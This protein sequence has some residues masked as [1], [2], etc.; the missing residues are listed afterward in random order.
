MRKT[1]YLRALDLKRPPTR[2][3]R[4]IA[5]DET[6]GL[7]IKRAVTLRLQT[8][9]YRERASFMGVAGYFFLDVGAESKQAKIVTN[10]FLKLF[11]RPHSVRPSLAQ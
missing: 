3:H 6:F 5:H 11:S 2:T 10:A 7:P 4:L 9:R 8:M 1:L